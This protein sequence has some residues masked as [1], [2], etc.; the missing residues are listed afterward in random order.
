MLVNEREPAAG[1]DEASWLKRLA[2]INAKQER[3]LNLY[4]SEDIIPAQFRTKSEELKE[5]RIAAEGQLEAVRSGLSRLEEME[6]SK[7]AIMAHYAS[8]VP[9]GL[10][11]LSSSERNQV[12]K[13]MRLQVH[14]GRDDTL[15][16]D[17]GCN[18]APLPLWSSIVTTPAPRFRAVLTSNG[19]GEIE[20]VEAQ[21]GANP[22]H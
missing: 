1:E 20:V 9:Q 3:L 13:T 7:D 14:A 8:L 15:I 10:A 22:G 11:G 12:Y 2:E 18:D 16:A 17:W 4:L 21:R 5:A 19:S 6:R